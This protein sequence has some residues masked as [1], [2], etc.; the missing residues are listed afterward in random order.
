MKDSRDILS[1]VLKTAQMGQI[2]IRSILKCPLGTGLRTELTTQLKEYEA[3]A[4]QAVRI[5]E[6]KG[7]NLKQLDPAIRS[8][9]DLMTRSRLHFGNADSRA[10]AMMI[11]GNTRGIIKGCRNR[12][13]LSTSDQRVVALLQKLLDTEQ[14]NNRQLQGFL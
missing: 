6:C 11:H 12:N 7:W 4:Q 8:M 13:Q 14:S 5:A 9:T 10:A 1:S 2:G 3:I